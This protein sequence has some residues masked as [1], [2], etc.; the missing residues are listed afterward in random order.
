MSEKA[1]V[2]ILTLI[3]LLVL[4]AF[5][6]SSETAISSIGRTRR[7]Q[8]RKSGK[9]RERVLVSLL[10][11]QSRSVTTLL[12]GNNIVNIW[13]SSIATA[14]AIERTGQ[15]GVLWATLIMTAVILLFSEITP[16][17]VAAQNPERTALFLAPAIALAKRLLSPLAFAF[18]A[19]NRACLSLVGVLFP[20]GQTRLTEDELRIMMRAGK[21]DGALEEKEHILLDK[22]VSFG[23][24]RVR[25][26]MTPRTA[27]AAVPPGL[28]MGEL[29][30]LFRERQY[31]RMPVYEDTIDTI[32]GMIHYKDILF[33]S[34]AGND[35]PTSD[36]VR[37]AVFVPESQTVRELFTELDSAGQNMAIVLDERGAT[38]GL[39]TMD[40]AIASILGAI[41]DEYDEEDR[42]PREMVQILDPRHLRVPGNLALDD[43][44]AL[45]K[46]EFDSDY[47]ETVGGYLMEIAGRL[48]ARGETIRQGSTVFRI[49]EQTGRTIQRI[50]ILL[51]QEKTG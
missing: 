43:L 36:L 37:P 35:A 14:L 8:L 50:E 12:I 10:E 49:E 38:A 4:S 7:R 11:D 15:G 30:A 44:N 45:L 39:V 46:T 9:K 1:L 33:A 48:P 31:S 42:R 6:S 2:S 3:V 20:G 51:E 40:D 34:D 26:I 22:A 32:T 29:T 16:K 27:I 13:A 25:E 23:G 28:N 18:S 5:F 41:R 47:Y 17:A 19:I 24:M 21:K